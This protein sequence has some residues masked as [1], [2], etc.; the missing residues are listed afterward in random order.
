MDDHKLGKAI[1]I[2]TREGWDAVASSC[3][4]SRG[5]WNSNHP[6]MHINVHF[7]NESGTDLVLCAYSVCASI[8]TVYATKF[9]GKTPNRY[10]GFNVNGTRETPVKLWEEET[11]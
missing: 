2:L 8:W 3:H 11:V 1:N 9:T 7:R 10:M 4:T 5:D 6:M